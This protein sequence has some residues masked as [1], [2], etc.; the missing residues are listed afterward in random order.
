MAGV[1][2]AGKLVADQLNAA[3][4]R[5]L[6][7]V[8]GPSLSNL[9]AGRWTESQFTNF[10]LPKRGKQTDKQTNDKVIPVNPFKPTRDAPTV[11]PGQ[12]LQEL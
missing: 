1:M 10:Q 3:Q 5:I 12:V 2:D 11:G 8:F 9:W 7:C 6:A 4:R